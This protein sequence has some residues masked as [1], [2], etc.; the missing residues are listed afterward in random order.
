MHAMRV[1]AALAVTPLLLGSSRPRSTDKA[2][3]PQR[4]RLAP[5][6]ACSLLTPAEVSAVLGE[7]ILPG[8]H[9]PAMPNGKVIM[10]LC[11][12]GPSADPGIEDKKAVLTIITTRSFENGTIPM[13]GIT[14]TPVSGI[15]DE[16]VFIITPGFGSGLNVRKGG[17]AFQIRVNGGHLT[18]QQEQDLEKALAKDVV[19]RL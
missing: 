13:Q 9:P 17:S 11:M 10:T 4:V 8:K 6:D 14:K 2:A 16:A 3:V 18:T 5:G 15:G 7:K 19:A 1:V 12:F